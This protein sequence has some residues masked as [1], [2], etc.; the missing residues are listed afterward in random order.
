MRKNEL[1]LYGHG[2]HS[3]NIWKIYSEG[4]TIHI[5]ANGCH[6]TEDVPCGKAGR[7]VEEQIKLRVEARARK[8]RDAGFKESREELGEFVT[9][10]LGL[11]APMLAHPLKRVKGLLFDKWYAQPKLDGH[12]CMISRQGAYSRQGKIIDT[13]PEIIDDLHVPEGVIFDGE[14]YYH[15]APL[16]TIASWAKRRQIK[17]LRLEYHIYDVVNE[18]MSFEDRFKFIQDN[19]T[20]TDKIKIVNTHK[21]RTGT[22]PHKLCRMYREQGYEG[23]IIRL[24]SSKY[25]IG[26]RS[27]H[28][29]KIKLR[30][31]DEFKCIDIEPSKEGW[32][33]LILEARNG[34]AFKTSAPGNHMEKRHVLDNKEDYIGKLVTCE[35]A[36]LTNDGIPFHC[37]AIRWRDDI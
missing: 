14:L 37:V 33:I 24:G 12:R 27:P 20:V 10:Q 30:E 28:L 36:E 4:N 19:V 7:S 13:I 21:L 35:Y 6:F 8:K 32:G 22:D 16:Q 11:P 17:T 2:V 9:N 26:K 15:G 25:S 23:A 31:D 18:N 29:I 3:I 1:T 34:N 5:Y